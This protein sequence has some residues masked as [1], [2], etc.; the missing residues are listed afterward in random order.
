MST[1]SR[2]SRAK[3]LNAPEN[4]LSW[5]RA[6]Q[7]DALAN[8]NHPFQARTVSLGAITGQDARALHA[9]AACMRLYSESDEPGRDA[10][11]SALRALVPSMQP[12]CWLF[13]REL[14]AQQLNWEDRD[15]IWR[16]LRQLVLVEVQPLGP[17]L[18]TFGAK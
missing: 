3:N 1:K 10:A 8:P 4:W 16:D 7:K 9:F 6:C 18:F 14:I 13:A 5:L 17:D 11:R 12:I 2:P 15:V